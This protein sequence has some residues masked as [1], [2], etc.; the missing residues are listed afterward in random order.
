VRRTSGGPAAFVAGCSACKL[1][2]L[3]FLP[4]ANI[5]PTFLITWLVRFKSIKS[6][7]TL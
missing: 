4:R 1:A 7:A 5:Q 2:Y 3:D 6:R